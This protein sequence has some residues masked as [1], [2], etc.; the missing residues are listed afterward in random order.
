[1]PKFEDKLVSDL[2]LK[3]QRE[4]LLT[5]EQLEAVKEEMDRTGKSF[6]ETLH[7][8]GYFTKEQRFKIFGDVVDV[9]GQKDGQALPEER[10]LFGESDNLLALIE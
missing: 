9:G 8:F 3:L 10:D 6:F 7:C 5:Q 4:G 1:M 2:A